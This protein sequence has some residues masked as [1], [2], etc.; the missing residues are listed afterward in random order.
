MRSTDRE[1]F[2]LVFIDREIFNLVFITMDY[3]V[4]SCMT[5]LQATQIR[6]NVR[7]YSKS[8]YSFLIPVIYL[9]SKLNSLNICTVFYIFDKTEC[10]AIELR[11]KSSYVNMMKMCAL[12]KF[13]DLHSF[14]PLAI[15]HVLSTRKKRITLLL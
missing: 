10:C 12:N 7:N 6:W 5:F 13:Q 11:E 2:N 4:C 14:S 8:L 9:R 1:I 3:N 15:F